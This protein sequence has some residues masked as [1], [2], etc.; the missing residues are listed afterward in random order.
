[1]SSNACLR[2][3]SA[4]ELLSHKFLK[5]ANKPALVELLK[6]VPDLGTAKPVREQC[7]IR[8]AAVISL[9][10]PGYLSVFIAGF[11]PRS[12]QESSFIDKE[13]WAD[14]TTGDVSVSAGM[15]DAATKSADSP[16]VPGVLPGSLLCSFHMVLN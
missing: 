16:Y 1:L 7:V 9:C 8:D 13:M 6:R 15:K 12:Y 4:A 2:R 14:I 5:S 11:A 3:K 10:R